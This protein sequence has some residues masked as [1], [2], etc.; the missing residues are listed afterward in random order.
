MYNP[1]GGQNY[2]LNSSISS[3][4]TEITL[5]SFT[6]PV[7]DTPYTMSN[8]NTDIAYGTIAPGTSS[9]EFIS[10][11]GITQND[12]GTAT[13]T[14]VTRG[15]AK[16]YPFTQDETFQL[17]H[18]GQSVFILSDAPQVFV[19]FA[20][21]E[22]DQSFT[23]VNTFEQGPLVPTPVSGTEAA[24]KDYVDGVAIAGAPNASNS[25]KGITKLSVAA[26]DPAQPIAVGD[27]DSRIPTTDQTAALAGVLGTPNASNPFETKDDTELNAIDQSQTTQDNTIATGEA[28]ATT[29]K[30]KVAQSFIAGKSSITGVVL[31]KSANTGTY[32]GDVTIALQANSTGS[33]SGSNLASLTIANADYNALAVGRFVAV[34]TVPY[35][36]TPG[37]TYWIVISSSSAD[38]SNH[39][40]LG[41]NSAGGYSS[42]SVKAFNTTDGWTAVA[43]IDLFFQILTNPVNKLVRIGSSQFATI[44]P[45]YA[46]DVGASDTYVV[47]VD[48]ISSY[49]TGHEFLLK[50][51][52]ANTGAA[53]LNINNL[54]A[55]SILRADGSALANGDISAN[56]FVTLAYNGTAFLFTSP[57]ANSPKFAH[58][59]A[60]RAGDTASSTQNIAHGM[61]RAP[62]FVEITVNHYQAT[63]VLSQSIGS[64]DGTT[65][66]CTYWF[67]TDTTTGGADVD[68]SNAIHMQV[69]TGGTNLGVVTV[70]ATNIIIT[71]TVSTGVGSTNM[72]I[73]WK[74]TA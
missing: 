26:V 1:A 45:P 10:F 21:L 40:N 51:P 32:V 37:T 55:K 4:V 34:F 69:A 13:L 64:Y 53:T 46:A 60:T 66:A 41:T 5:T 49:V 67:A 7:S 25:T 14:G 28:D 12:D 24:N 42:G 56:Q 38:N 70:D 59:T 57:L 15:L 58:G 43:T 39:P 17:P 31:Y 48:G 52:T 65:Q 44:F 35:T 8:L 3:T 6:E 73:H 22:N 62:R 19:K 72:M 74:A 16:K 63:N 20:S 9:S 30:N 71:W 18:S 27:N 47:S 33:P 54:G 68:T 29:K 61:G 2:A 36:S 11:T 50:L 23:G